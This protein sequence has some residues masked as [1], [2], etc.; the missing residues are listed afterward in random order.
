MILRRWLV[1]ALTGV[2]SVIGKPAIDS[3]VCHESP[4]TCARLL[5]SDMSVAELVPVL[6]F[7]KWFLF[8]GIAP[9]L[10]PDDSL[11]DNTRS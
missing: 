10:Q 9:I 2:W 4:H 7:Q 8:D 1:N 5:D 3:I 11:A 6:V